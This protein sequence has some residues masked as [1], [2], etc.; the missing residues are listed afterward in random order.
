MTQGAGTADL[1]LRRRQIAALLCAY[2]LVG[3]VSLTILRTTIGSVIAFWLPCGL[4]LALQARASPRQRPWLFALQFAI[5]F[6]VETLFGSLPS[7]PLHLVYAALVAGE[8]LLAGLAFRRYARGPGVQ[9]VRAVAALA[10][11][12][13]GAASVFA[14]STTC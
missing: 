6:A 4:G 10:L 3:A 14:L 11:S 13:V 2:A 1:G 12:A 7:V 8:S 5:E 9:G